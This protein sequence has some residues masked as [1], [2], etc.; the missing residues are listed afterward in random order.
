MPAHPV[1]SGDL[2]VSCVEGYV[3]T[4]S[5]GVVILAFVHHTACLNDDVSLA[6]DRL[7]SVASGFTVLAVVLA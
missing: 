1:R 6:Y 5:G 2:N 3:G 7:M 4:Q